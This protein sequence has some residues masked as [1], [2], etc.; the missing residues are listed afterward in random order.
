MR[1]VQAVLC[2]QVD[3]VLPFKILCCSEGGETRATSE[4]EGRRRAKSITR[5]G[6]QVA[7]VQLFYRTGYGAPRNVHG[8]F[9]G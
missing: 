9:A 2:T 8:L 3:C 5:C 7:S 1:G 6:Y 4:E